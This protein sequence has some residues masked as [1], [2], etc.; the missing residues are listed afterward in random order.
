MFG[1][2]HLIL[3]SGDFTWL[4]SEYQSMC[5]MCLFVRSYFLHSFSRAMRGNNRSSQFIRQNT[6]E[7]GVD[8][9]KVD[10]LRLRLY[11]CKVCAQCDIQQETSHYERSLYWRG[12]TS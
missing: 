5:L 2:Y 6:S 7:R 8:G 10:L 1:N 12:K 3:L 4:S 9:E 11:V